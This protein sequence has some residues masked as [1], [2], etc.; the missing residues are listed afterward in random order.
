MTLAECLARAEM[1]L[2]DI[3]PVRAWSDATPVFGFVVHTPTDRLVALCGTFGFRHGKMTLMAPRAYTVRLEDG[4]AELLSATDAVRDLTWL[5]GDVLLGTSSHP[6]HAVVRW[7]FDGAWREQKRLSLRKIDAPGRLVCGEIDGR[8]LA[9]SMGRSRCLVIDTTS[10]TI[11]GHIELQVFGIK[12]QDGAFY[13]KTNF[14]KEEWRPVEAS[15]LP[16]PA[17]APIKTSATRRTVKVPKWAT[18]PVTTSPALGL[19][20]YAVP[21]AERGSLCAALGVPDDSRLCRVGATV[22]ALHAKARCVYVSTPEGV[23]SVELPCLGKALIPSPDGRHVLIA[24]VRREGIDSDEL[25]E[26]TL[27]PLDK[28]PLV[29]CLPRGSVQDIWE[30]LWLGP[31][32]I[33]IHERKHFITTGAVVCERAQGAWLVRDRISL[34]RYDALFV[35]PTRGW[36]VTLKGHDLIV[37]T[38]PPTGPSEPVARATVARRPRRGEYATLQRTDEGLVFRVLG[39]RTGE[40]L[41]SCRLI[42]S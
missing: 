14:Y 29:P 28:G 12:Y 42:E 19:G 38:L 23:V 31:D 18:A 40:A 15:E 17:A 7:V 4:A 33:V 10:L 8:L 1:E 39:V 41:Y 22:L 37:Y 24:G 32:R 36:I 16:A 34:G 21:Y 26:L 5:S 11:L 9:L 27:D 2:P 25:V 6:T 20:P 30:V 35:D 13:L 3:G